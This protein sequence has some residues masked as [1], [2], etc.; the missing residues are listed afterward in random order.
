MLHKQLTAIVADIVPE[1]PSTNLSVIDMLGLLG[2][3]TVFDDDNFRD[4]NPL[5]YIRKTEVLHPLHGFDVGFHKNEATD[6][7]LSAGQGNG[8]HDN[9]VR[10]TDCNL[11]ILWM[12]WVVY[13]QKM[14][15]LSNNAA[16]DDVGKEP[17]LLGTPLFEHNR[18][19]HLKNE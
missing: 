1:L 12:E 17:N 16:E 13:L 4:F 7:E 8:Y 15:R 19:K 10:P 9:S 18:R 5:D 11:A 3:G 14:D 2:H 6:D